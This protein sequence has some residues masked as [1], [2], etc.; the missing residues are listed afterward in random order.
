MKNPRLPQDLPTKR[1]L[2]FFYSVPSKPVS[3][4]M[5]IWRMLTKSGAVQFKGS[6]YILPDSEDHYEFFQW[7]V[8]S[9]STMK[10][11]AAFVRIEK[12]ETMKDA[13]IIEMFN[14]NRAKDYR[15]IGMRLDDL[16][17]KIRAAKKFAGTVINKKFEDDMHKI[18]KDFQET[19]K[20]DFFHSDMRKGLEKRLNSINAALA[21]LT[22]IVNKDPSVEIIARA[23]ADYQ[24]KLWVT[25]KRPFVDRMASAWLIKRFIDKIPSFG[26]VDENDL[27]HVSMDA[28]S[29]DIMG[30]E[31]THVGDLCTF[32][33]LLK[34]FK[35]NE[36]ALD[37]IGE[38]IHQ[39]DV[40]DEKYRNPAAEGLHEIL[41]GVR[42]TARDDHEALEKGM[43]I[44]EM[45]YASKNTPHTN[46]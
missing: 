26:F 22:G 18:E 16:A 38:I 36:K 9:V 2:L 42:R 41:D 24:G 31:F 35:L 34:A 25:R 40:N 28:V 39:L 4:R 19:G 43:N 6:I 45:L 27:A 30:G 13:D 23:V 46:A 3:T 21:T 8:S 20:T 11:E 5:K 29:Y 1:W 10:G 32:E 14:Q 12:I 15:D 44:M 37:T 17:D 33:V 7:L